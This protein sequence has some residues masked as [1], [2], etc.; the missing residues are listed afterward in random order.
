MNTKYF[1]FI[2][3]TTLLIIQCRQKNIE[4]NQ[5]VKT[6]QLNQ[7]EKWKV[8]DEMMPYLSAMQEMILNYDETSG[9]YKTL[10]TSLAGHN[11]KLIK[12]CTMQGESH[13]QLHLWLHPYLELVDNLNNA[14]SSDEA[15]AIIN[16]IK[17]S[18][19]TFKNYFQ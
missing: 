1:F 13:D 14:K 15:S 12:S 8:N 3:A 19:I 16:Q 6:L 2:I 7:G 11:K 18:F 17:E 5:S 4:T 9:D 10:A